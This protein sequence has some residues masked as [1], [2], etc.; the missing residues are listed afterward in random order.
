[1]LAESSSML[2]PAEVTYLRNLS[3]MRR[4]P[5]PWAVEALDGGSKSY[6]PTT[7]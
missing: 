1:M 4:F 7:G 2:L 3:Q 6:T 5:A